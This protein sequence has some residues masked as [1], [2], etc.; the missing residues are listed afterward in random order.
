MARRY[1]CP[2]GVL[3][4]NEEEA[5]RAAAELVI[6]WLSSPTTATRGRGSALTTTPE[7]IRGLCPGGQ[8]SPRLLVEKQI[9]GRHYRVLVVGDRVVAA[10]ERI[11]AS[12][13]GNGTNTIAELI[14]ITN[15]DPRRGQG[16]EKPLTKITVEEVVLACLRRRGISLEYVPPPGERVSQG[17]RQLSTGGTATMSRTKFIPTMFWHSAGGPTV[18][19][20]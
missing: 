20:M 13:V 6:P 4:H 16:H 1:S 14:E 7:E 5:L 15:R 12:V 9:P 19:L 3:V 8:Y 18:G 17:K 11:P 10:A 2:A